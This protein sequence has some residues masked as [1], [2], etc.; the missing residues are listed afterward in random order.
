[1]HVALVLTPWMHPHRVTEW[2]ESIS[3]ALSRKADVLEEYDEV[4]RSPSITVQIPAVLRL[5]KN[6]AR[7]KTDEKFSR[8]NVYTRD[9]WTCQYC[10]EKKTP[11]QLTY[12]HVLPFSKGG[13]TDWHIIVSACGRCNRRKANKT[14]EKAGMRLLKHPVKPRSLP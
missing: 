2:H 8:S 10:G 3:L 11:R 7:P 9:Q 13:K 5:K 1:M 4:V 14:P 6:L 12:D